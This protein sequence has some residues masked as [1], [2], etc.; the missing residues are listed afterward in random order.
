M[1]KHVKSSSRERGSVLIEFVFTFVFLWIPL[2]FGTLVLGLN[3]VRAVQVTQ[4]CRD[5]AHLH[6]KGVDFT[7]AL[8]KQLLAS[9]APGLNVDTTG[10]AG[11]TVVILSTLTYV[12][13]AQCQAG[14]YASTC[15]NYQKTVFTRRIV[16][17]KAS[18]HAS[19]YGTPKATLID[20]AGNIASG[21]N[22]GT[23]GYLNDSSAV[24]AGFPALLTSGQQYAYVAETFFISSDPQW[25][26]FLG[27][28]NVSAV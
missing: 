20:S 24:A 19:N 22:S 8:S 17:G 13:T 1:R 4:L 2:F 7:Q 28:P 21:N 3:L 12:D 25:W 9:L 15:P 23:K 6:S 26:A 11:N 10:A 14:G 18:L 16:V 5:G 27:S